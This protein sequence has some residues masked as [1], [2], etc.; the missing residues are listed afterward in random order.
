MSRYKCIIFDFDG[1]LAD[2]NVGIVRTFQETFRQMGLPV[3][4]RERI[5]STIGLVLTDGFKAASD[6]LSD[7]DADK[8][9][10]VYRRIF[11]E[12]AY[13]VIT[14]FPGVV[15]TVAELRGLGLRLAVA[16][17]RSH[18][19]LDALAAQIGVKEYFEG[20][21]GAEDVEHCKPAPDLA[22]L[23]IRNMGIAPEDALVVGDATFDLLMGHAAGC[24]VCG[25]TWGNQSR[26]ALQSAAPEYIVDTLDELL[27]I[28]RG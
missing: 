20:L 16:T 9:A 25:V 14:A 2:T 4:S 5:S 7:E 12:I 22:D 21:Y 19:S 1:T 6:G 26:E 27:E 28:V 15:E 24:D 18:H 10:V 3:P 11:P 13:P 8:A 23:I 17:S